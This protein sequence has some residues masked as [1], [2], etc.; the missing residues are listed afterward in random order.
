MS[1]EI[2]IL[3]RLATGVPVNQDEVLR[4]LYRAAPRENDSWG[5]ER[6]L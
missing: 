4:L 2:E 3:I 6:R 5:F 1:S